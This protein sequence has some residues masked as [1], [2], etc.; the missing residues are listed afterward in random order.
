MS[1][2]PTVLVM[3]S[4]HNGPL[5]KTREAAFS[6]EIFAT[7]YFALDDAGISTVIATPAGGQASTTAVAGTSTEA[8]M[9][10]RFRRDAR[11]RDMFADTLMIEQIFAPD[12]DAMIAVSATDGLWD[13]VENDAATR[14]V[15]ELVALGRP[16][17]LVGHA[18]ALLCRPCSAVPSMRGRDVTGAS[19]KEDHKACPDMQFP[20]Q[21]EDRLQGIGSHY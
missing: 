12:F 10:D 13:L 17:V 16:V 11:A 5:V 19:K 6:T 4:S 18:A 15:D 14:I 8:A 7:L 3:L 21:V 20:L 9:P 1:R 2:V